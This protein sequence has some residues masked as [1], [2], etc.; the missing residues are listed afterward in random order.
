MDAIAESE[1]GSAAC[2]REERTERWP[3]PAGWAAPA[4]RSVLGGSHHASHGRRLGA[5]QFYDEPRLF[6]LPCVEPQTTFQAFL[7]IS[8]LPS[9]DHPAFDPFRQLPTCSRLPCPSVHPASPLTLPGVKQL[10]SIINPCWYSG[11]KMLS[12]PPTSPGSGGLLFLFVLHICSTQG[13]FS[14]PKRNGS[15]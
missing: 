9:S 10:I 5:L 11:G 6:S 2:R 7:S 8:D 3:R 4:P 15:R 14:L 12:P 13:P 1:A